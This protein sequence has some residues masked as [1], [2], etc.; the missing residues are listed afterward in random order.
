MTAHLTLQSSQFVNLRVTFKNSPIHVLEKFTFKNI[1]KAHE[2]FIESREIEECIILQTCNRVEIYGVGNNPQIDKIIELWSDLIYV[3]I[4]E[5]RSNIIVDI[6]EEAIKHL[7]KLTSGLD[8]LVVGEDQILG[9]VKRS[10]EFSRKNRF[11]GQNLNVLFDRTIRIGSKVRT[12]TGI[13]KGSISVGSM[14]VN[15]ALEY[16]DDIN[17]KEILLIGSGEGA[18]LIAKALKQRNI[19]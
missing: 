10:L 7:A 11:S 12:D 3:P 4:D 2:T 16:F 5:V 8:S 13:N 1:H 9:Q 17:E 14:A 19:K 15:L 18:T 6:G